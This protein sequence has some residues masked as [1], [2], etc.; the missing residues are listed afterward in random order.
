MDA[1]RSDPDIRRRAWR[2]RLDTA[3]WSRKP[4][5]GHLALV[6]LERQG[7]LDLLV[8]QNVDG[9]HRAA[10]TDPERLV[11][12]HG[13]V[14]EVVCL[15]CRDRLPMAVV[16]VRVDA[17]EEDPPCLVCGGILKPAVVFFG[18]SLDPV[19]LERAFAASERCD[20]FLVVGSSLT[21][22]PIN[23]TA[24]TAVGAGARLVIV[25]AEPTPFDRFADVVLRG[26]ISHV[27]P[28]IVASSLG[29]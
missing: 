29:E 7:G 1:Y 4:N 22:Y 3:M 19:D 25:N 5:P 27:L 23:E 13:N 26:S 18:E 12:V 17:G 15:S 16:A 8:T 11:E 9:L 28:E 24:G 14:R 6:D 20:L 10:G 2:R 21:V